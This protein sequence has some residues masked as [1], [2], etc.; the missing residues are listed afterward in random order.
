MVNEDRAALFG[1]VRSALTQTPFSQ[2]IID[3]ETFYRQS[4]E[5]GVS[6]LFYPVL[7]ATKIS[8]K[9]YEKYRHE[10]Y[11]YQAQDALYLSEIKAIKT[12]FSNRD[13]PFIFLKGANL[14][15]IYPMS[16]MRAMG[17]IDILIHEQDHESIP[18]LMS[19][20]GYRLDTKGITHDLYLKGRGLIVEVHHRIDAHFHE[21]HIDVLQDAWQRKIPVE[22]SEYRLSHEDELIYLLAHLAKHM[23]SSGVGIRSVLDIGIFMK[24][25]ETSLDRARVHALIAQAGLMTF[26][27]NLL[28][29]NQSWFH[30]EFHEAYNV[31]TISDVFYDDITNYVIG[32]GIHGHAA[33]FNQALPGITKVAVRDQTVR[34]SRIKYLF[35]VMFPKYKELLPAHPVLKRWKILL[36]WFWVKRWFRLIFK[37][38]RRSIRKLKAVNVDSETIATHMALFQELGL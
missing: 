2:A 16:Y 35:R 33:G 20:L 29:L 5:N 4:R 6:G 1:L 36:P 28:A 12:H 26:F 31:P 22:G 19:A 13:I 25:Y 14:K 7:D 8:P 21:A 10:H 32:S 15:Q 24:A 17:D 9:Y 38:T 30:V 34:R 27:S 18:S 11:R 23:Y 37:Q 3:E